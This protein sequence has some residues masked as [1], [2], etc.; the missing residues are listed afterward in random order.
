M[1]R[2]LTHVYDLTSILTFG[3]SELPWYV[4]VKV[5]AV[6]RVPVREQVIESCM[7]AWGEIQM[8]VTQRHISARA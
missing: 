3:D 6:V 1:T 5:G 2:E 7:L 4:R 8:H